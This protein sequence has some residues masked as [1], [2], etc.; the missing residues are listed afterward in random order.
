MIARRRNGIGVAFALG[1]ATLMIQSPAGAI[2]GGRSVRFGSYRWMVSLRLASAPNAHLCAGTLIAADMVLTAAHC[3]DGHQQHDF[4]AVVGVDAPAW[5]AAKKVRILGFREPASFNG[6]ANSNRDDIAVL[7]L[8]VSQT[9]P[10][11]ALASAQPK[12][13]TMLST[14]GWGC[15]GKP[16]SCG[17]TPS[18]RLKA[19]AQTVLADSQCGGTVFKAPRFYGPTAIC[20][21]GTGT[22]NGGDSGGPL[23][24][25]NTNK[26][27]VETGVTSM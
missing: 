12:V 1:I 21:K 23:L 5:R 13:G 7:R 2:Y 9:G 22:V 15:T 10:T 3:V 11:I 17:Q 27:F 25:G 18:L 16:P 8:A 20:T 26:G 4:V 19:T 24:V 14:A 6:S